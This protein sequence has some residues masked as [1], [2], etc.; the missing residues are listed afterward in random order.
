M[1][2]C[3]RR[4]RESGAGGEAF[5][6]IVMLEV[7]MAEPEETLATKIVIRVPLLTKGTVDGE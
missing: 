6:V 3:H 4:A 1:L 7:I 5:I 2:L